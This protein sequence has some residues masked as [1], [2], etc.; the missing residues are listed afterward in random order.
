MR[1][2]RRGNYARSR[3]HRYRK[4]G[5]GG[6]TDYT[7]L[8]VLVTGGAGFIGSN[9]VDA[10]LEAG[11]AKVRVLDN[12]TT[13]K[14]SNLDKARTVG[15]DRFEFI[16]GSITDYKTCVEA[17]E[18]MN[19][20]FH[21][22]ALVSVPRSMVDP[23]L[24]HDINITGTLNMLKAAS[25]AGV[26]RFVY[27]SSAAT[28]GMLPELPKVET[29]QRDY[30]SPYALSKGVCE[31]YAN[32][33]AL[34]EMLGGGMTCVGLRYFNVYGPRQDPKSPYSGVISIFTD[35]IS[36]RE[37]ITINGDGSNTRD[38]V[39]VADVVKANMLSGRVDIPKTEYRV[40]NVGT[41]KSVT[42]LE[43]IDTIK[44]IVGEE[45]NVQLGDE[46]PG[47]IK[48]SVSEISKIRSELGYEPSYTLDQGLRILMKPA[49]MQGGEFSNTFGNSKRKMSFAP[50]HTRK[51]YSYAKS[52]AKRSSNNS[53]NNSNSN[54]NIQLANVQ[55]IPRNNIQSMQPVMSVKAPNRKY[56]VKNIQK[57]H[58]NTNTVRESKIGKNTKRL[59]ATISRSPVSSVATYVNFAKNNRDNSSV[60]GYAEYKLNESSSPKYPEIIKV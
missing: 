6:G 16:E 10:L 56:T 33:Y 37:Q 18:G 5:G 60:L 51:N 44:D 35:K 9:L 27:A 12:L 29:M 21:E 34:K 31:D 24:N 58:I 32:L 49:P 14:M 3:T 53:S 46:R 50:M 17:C 42:L 23:I 41:G 57:Y 20:V 7:G 40:Y 15:A 38:F 13:G 1:F 54:S 59:S 19:V 11:A 55:L 26:S 52:N 47:D 45:V 36:N 2:T 30:P 4:T 25:E 28:Y 39:F 48:H 22:A 43:L 8:S